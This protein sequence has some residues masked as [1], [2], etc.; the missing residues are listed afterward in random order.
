[1]NPARHENSFLPIKNK[2]APDPS[3]ENI[4]TSRPIGNE[5]PKEFRKKAST[6]T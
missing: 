4:G 1:M 5:M 2:S 3:V 6:E